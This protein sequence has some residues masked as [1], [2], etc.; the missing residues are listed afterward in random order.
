M[1]D[2]LQELTQ[3]KGYLTYAE[4]VQ[5]A[6]YH[7]EFGYYTADRNRVGKTPDSD[8][9]TSM[10]LGKTFGKLVLESVHKLMGQR[11]LAEY[12]FV[13]I[14][15]EPETSVLIDLDHCFADHQIIRLGDPLLLSSDKCVVFSNEWLDAQPFHR[16]VFR[17]GKWR[18]LGVKIGEDSLEEIELEVPSEEV[19]PWLVRLPEQYYEDYHF[20]VP[21]GAELILD[22][23]MQQNWTGL[24]LTL[25]YGKSLQE[26]LEITPQGTARAYYRHH[27]SNDLLKQPGQQ[28]LTCHL[29]W[30]WLE[31][32]MAK[33]S[34]DEI[35]TIRQESLFMR[36]ATS[37]IQQ[38]LENPEYPQETGR[39]KELLHPSHMGHRFQ[40]L[41]GIR[42]KKH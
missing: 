41:Y 2:Y 23:I 8:F 6:V 24:F 39:I 5:E 3:T 42:T 29:C 21:S 7:P 36:Y 34:F 27:Q 10:S 15:A 14:A 31:T 38:I 33:H 22:E 28:D 17:Q 35:S 11:E 13:E 18:E 19:Q 1:Q 32:T 16:L 12:T 37:A 25:D 20:D 30:D 9:Y 40:A 26:L 4:F